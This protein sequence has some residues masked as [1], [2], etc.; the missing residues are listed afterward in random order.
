MRFFPN[1]AVDL[2]PAVKLLVQ[3]KDK[4]ITLSSS[5]TESQTCTD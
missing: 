4:V 3:L 1:D 2:E 5:C